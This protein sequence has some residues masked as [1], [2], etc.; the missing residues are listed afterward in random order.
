[1]ERPFL[2]DVKIGS[3][4]SYLIRLPFVG[5]L[6]IVGFKYGACYQIEA[7]WRP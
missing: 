3:I 2:L 6:F 1:M 4:L 5:L 7:F